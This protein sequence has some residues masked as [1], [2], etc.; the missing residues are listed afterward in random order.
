MKLI[1]FCADFS[2]LSKDLIPV[3]IKYCEKKDYEYQ[4]YNIDD[5][6]DVM[7]DFGLFGMPPALLIMNDNG[8]VVKTW[9]GRFDSIDQVMAS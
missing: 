8:E 4:I 2:R 5:D 6:P 1:Y 7:S 3:V 9:K